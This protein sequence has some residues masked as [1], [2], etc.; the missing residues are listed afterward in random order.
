MKMVNLKGIV[1]YIYVVLMLVCWVAAIGLLIWQGWGWFS[2][3]SWSSIPV[4]AA[5]S[6][7]GGMPQGF[8]FYSNVALGVIA[9]QSLALAFALLGGFC[10]FIA[11]ITD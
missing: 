10:S 2:T 7:F 8:E 1:H 11:K 9:K 5:F 3:G 4:E 6:R